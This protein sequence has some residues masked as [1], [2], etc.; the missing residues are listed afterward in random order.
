MK[1]KTAKDHFGLNINIL[2]AIID[3]IIVPVSYLFKA[4]INEG[5]YPDILKISQI[6]PLPEGGSEDE[7]GNLR[8]IALVPVISKVFETYIKEELMEHFTTNE[9]F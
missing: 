2:L 1:N 3:L 4:A 5:T 8:P 9:I 6:I 7:A